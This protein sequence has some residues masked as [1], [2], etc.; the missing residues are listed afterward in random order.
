MMR[1]QGWSVSRD[2]F[3]MRCDHQI[4][5][6]ELVRQGCGIGGAQCGIADADPLV[7]RVLPEVE[8]PVLPLWL[9]APQAL[10][11]NPRIRRVWDVLAAELGP[12]ANST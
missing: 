3:P 7:E 12:Q 4:V 8:L 5:Q 9:A 1:D 2:F 6:W 10:R 11:T